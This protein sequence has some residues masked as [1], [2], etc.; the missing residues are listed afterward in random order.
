MSKSRINLWCWLVLLSMS[1]AQNIPP[2]NPSVASQIT[3]APQSGLQTGSPIQTAYSFINGLSANSVTTTVVGGTTTVLPIWYCAP[4]ETAAA[5]NKNCPEGPVIATSNPSCGGGFNA[6]VLLPLVAVPGFFLP[7]P[8]GLPTLTI[9]DGEARTF[10]PPNNPS[11]QTSSPVSTQTPTP[12]PTPQDDSPP[13]ISCLAPAN[14]VADNAHPASSTKTL[15]GSATLIPEAPL[16]IEA[17]PLPFLKLSEEGG[18]ANCGG[19]GVEGRYFAGGFNQFGN[20]FSR[21][22]GISALNQFCAA[23]SKNGSVLGPDGVIGSDK[24]G[25]S[26][27]KAQHI[28]Q[29]DFNTKKSGKITV[30]A[31]FD[32]DNRISKLN[33]EKDC[34]HNGD[35]EG[36]VWL[37]ALFQENLCRNYFGQ[38]IDFCDEGPD[39]TGRRSAEDTKWKRGGTYY[40]RCG[41]YE[42]FKT[43]D[44][45]YTRPL[46]PDEVLEA[47][48]PSAK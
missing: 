12:T 43:P 34:N 25:W 17:N 27:A 18:L 42:I 14:K 38:S 29:G 40:H 23:H 45:G 13:E 15:D 37:I 3:M 22:D 9:G 36:K 30:R 26:K 24:P 28:Y 41:I 48:L 31:I 7:P 39:D 2:P 16:D 6:V 5:C 4:R 44:S 8:E 46:K 32:I 33:S 21:N 47:P 11:P 20:T 1:T 10:T 19:G 35:D